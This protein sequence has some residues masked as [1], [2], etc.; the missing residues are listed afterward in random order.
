M[1]I[2]KNMN[3]EWAKWAGNTAAHGGNAGTLM[4]DIVNSSVNVDKR[5]DVDG[6]YS[7]REKYQTPSS[8]A[9]HNVM[10][11]DKREAPG[12]I[13]FG[14]KLAAGASGLLSN[15][16]LGLTGSLIGIV[17]GTGTLLKKGIE[18]VNQY[19]KNSYVA[20][21][22][23]TYDKQA[24]KNRDSR[25]RWH[26]AGTV[27]GYAPGM[28]VDSAVIAATGGIA[29]PALAGVKAGAVGVK[30]A[31]IAAKAAK[32][33]DKVNS[34]MNAA[35]TA[36]K[37]SYDASKAT[38]AASIA[39]KQAERAKMLSG[40]PTQ[41]AKNVAM[42]KAKQIAGTPMRATGTALFSGMTV[43]SA[44]QSTQQAMA[45]EAQNKYYV[46]PY[47]D[48]YYEQEQPSQASWQDN[49]PQQYQQY[50]QQQQYQ[51]QYQ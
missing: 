23:N 29:A 19:G 6:D 41:V 20:D 25:D 7:W 22:W 35:K 26:T 51:Q 34:A 2:L 18:T 3:P 40:T 50:P 17:P 21:N 44:H 37:T 15:V 8:R 12:S 4:D 38:R 16:D 49:Q 13:S 33:G 31:A 14:E 46:D 32:A 11:G 24:L 42:H 39:A 30:A 10:K 36:A 48:E 9:Y 5:D 28:A 1:E 45:P 43:H 27:V 47:S